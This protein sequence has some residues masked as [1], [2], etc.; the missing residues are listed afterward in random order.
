TPECAA[1]LQA[2]LETLGKK[3]GPEDGRSEGQRFHDALQLACQ[4]LLRADL[5]PDRAGADARLDGVISLAELLRLT[6]A[7]QLQESWLAALAG[8]PGYLA[9]KDAEAV[10]CDAVVSPV[11]TGS[12]DVTVVDTMIDV[13]LAYLDGD[14]DLTRDSEGGHGDAGLARDSDRGDSCSGDGG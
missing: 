1:S 13:I 2:V 9:G 5:A 11:V 14:G 12:P 6:G 7:S 4:L 8:Q 3:A 10:A